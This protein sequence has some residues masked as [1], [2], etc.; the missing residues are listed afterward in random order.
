MK[1]RFLA[2][3]AMSFAAFV[4]LPPRAIAS[5]G[6]CLQGGVC[7]IPEKGGWNRGIC[8]YPPKGLQ[9]PSSQLFMSDFGWGRPPPYVDFHPKKWPP[10]PRLDF[11]WGPPPPYVDFHP[12]KWPMHPRLDFELSL[13]TNYP[14]VLAV[15][16]NKF[17]RYGKKYSE[18][19]SAIIEEPRPHPVPLPLPF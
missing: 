6:T 4:L 2:L 18:S 14:I 1:I 13:I 11:G 3:V 15:S 8:S 19:V 7:V 12:K 16:E 10:H 5:C 9:S 17:I